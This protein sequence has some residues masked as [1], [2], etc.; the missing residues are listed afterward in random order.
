MKATIVSSK[1]YLIF[2]ALLALT[3]LFLLSLFVS[4]PALALES[5]LITNSATQTLPAIYGNNVVWGDSRN[6]N[7]DIYMYNLTTGGESQITSDT[8]DQSYPD[9]YGNKI[10]WTDS[11]NGNDDIYM[12]NLTTGQTTQITTNTADQENPKIYGNKIV[13]SDLRNISFDIYMYNLTTGQT[14]RI[15]TDNADQGLAAIYGNKIVWR[16]DRNGSSNEDIYMYNLTTGAESQITAIAGNQSFPDIYGNKIVWPDG[17]YGSADIYLYNLSTGFESRITTDTDLQIFPRIYGNNIVWS[18]V[19]NSNWDI[20]RYDISGNIESQVTNSSG[21]QYLATIYGNKMVWMDNRNG[22][23]DLYMNTINMSARAMAKTEGWDSG[24]GNWDWAGSKVASGDFNGDGLMDLVAFYGYGATRQTKAWVFLNN[25]HGGYGSPV[26]WWDSGPNN[27]DWAGTKLTVG[28]YNGDGLADI[29]AL[30]GYAAQHQ[31]KAFIFT[32]NGTNGFNTP[33]TWW[34]SGPG[35]WDWAGT[36]LTS[37]D[38]NGDGVDDIGALYGYAAQHETRAFIFT[39]NGVDA[40]N[41]PATWWDSGP[42]NWD[43]AGT[44]LSSGDY[45]ADGL[46]DMSA[47]Y[48]YATQHQTRAFVFTSNGI[49]AFNNPT[50]WWDSGAGNWDWNGSTP[51][52]GDFSGDGRDDLAVFY[53]YGGNQ[54]KLWQFDSDATTFAA[55][56]AA[57]DSGAG[58]WNYANSKIVSGDT[59]GDARADISAFYNY[60]GT[61]RTKVFNLK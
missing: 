22:N 53:G 11:R 21:D 18:D 5:P 24:I 3:V 35:N 58:N 7:Y 41:N 34:N 38:Y 52:S 2:F 19:R 15:T 55:P 47:L 50:A 20:Y 14:T 10:V 54:A 59:N 16:D 60:S 37:G 4:A 31:T 1:S 45:N 61:H 9:I 27:W 33:A 26:A 12:Y 39:S 51:L 40:F 42:G 29:G 48:G 23:W 46:S 57:W 8:A 30:Y 6:G 32:S 43:W 13:W 44:K 17:R 49:S 25:G 36:K 56:Y 28:D